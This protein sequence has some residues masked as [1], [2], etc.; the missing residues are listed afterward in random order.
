MSRGVRQ[1]CPLSPLLYAI[2]AEIL[3]ER[4]LQVCPDVMVRAYA[5]DTAT[6]LNDFWSEALKIQQIFEDFSKVSGL[7]LNIKK[8]III[9]LST[10]PLE[11]F[12]SPLAFRSIDTPMV[13]HAGGSHRHVPRFQHRP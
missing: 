9:S 6:V 1:G 13:G 4:I 11:A 2:V 3:L 10:G 12:R 7:E 5:D 8:T